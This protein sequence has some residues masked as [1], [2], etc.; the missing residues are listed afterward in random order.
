MKKSTI[1]LLGVFLIVSVLCV[2]EIRNVFISTK[3]ELVELIK[4]VAMSQSKIQLSIQSRSDY[5]PRLIE[6]AEKNISSQ[7]EILKD[8]ESINTQIANCIDLGRFMEAEKYNNKLTL[9]LENLYYMYPVLMENEKF[10]ELRKKIEECEK[11]INS[12]IGEY[13]TSAKEFNMKLD[14]IPANIV[15]KMLGYNQMKY[16][17]ADES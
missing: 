12:A 8:L 2:C 7:T 15:A 9:K 5:I 3:S 17:K 16:F 1:K 13:N 14:Q 4:N 10:C 11:D 6:E